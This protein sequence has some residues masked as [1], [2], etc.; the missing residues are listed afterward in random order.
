MFYKNWKTINHKSGK[1][2]LKEDQHHAEIIEIQTGLVVEDN[3]MY[4]FH[5][6][7]NHSEPLP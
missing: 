3:I 6:C 2:I 7:L 5:E 1:L 4:S